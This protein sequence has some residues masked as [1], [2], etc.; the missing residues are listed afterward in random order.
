MRIQAAKLYTICTIVLF[1]IFGIAAP[2]FVYL[3]YSAPMRRPVLMSRSDRFPTSR[4]SAVSSIRFYQKNHP[5]LMVRVVNDQRKIKQKLKA[6]KRLEQSLGQIK[7]N[8]ES[9]TKTARKARY[10]KVRVCKSA[11]RCYWKRVRIPHHR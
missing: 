7:E 2:L 10:Y 9:L 8:L 3:T 11:S 5:P 1:A 6:A 4:P